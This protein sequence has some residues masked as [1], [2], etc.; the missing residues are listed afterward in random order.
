MSLSA[1]GPCLW[2]SY[3]A[4]LHVRRASVTGNVGFRNDDCYIGLPFGGLRLGI[5]VV[6]ATHVRAWLHELDL[7]LVDTLPVVDPACFELPLRKPR[8]S[9]KLVPTRG[10]GACSA[11]T[12]SSSAHDV[13]SSTNNHQESLT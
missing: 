10:R 5:E 12:P 2:W 6:D 8:P 13:T 3:P 1:Q 9:K 4:H 7:G 11:Q